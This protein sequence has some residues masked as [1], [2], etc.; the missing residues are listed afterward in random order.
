MKRQGTCFDMR[1]LS[2]II[3]WEISF[4][5]GVVVLCSVVFVG[6]SGGVGGGV[7]VCFLFRFGLGFLG[8]F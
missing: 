5:S 8:F 7:F 4:F 3:L 1:A 2:Q 6:F